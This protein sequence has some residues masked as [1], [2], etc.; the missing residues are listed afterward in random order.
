MTQA[1]AADA[2]TKLQ[3]LT[4]ASGQL[5]TADQVTPFNSSGIGGF[6]GVTIYPQS[7]NTG[8]ANAGANE[9]RVYQFV[10]PYA[11]TI[12]KVTVTVSTS[13]AGAAD[14]GIYNSAGTRLLY[15][16][17][18]INTGSQTTQTV[19][20][21]SGPVTLIAGVYYFAQTTNGVTPNFQ[22]LNSFT[23]LGAILNNNLVRLGTAANN[24]TAGVLPSTLGTITGAVNVPPVLAFFER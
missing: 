15:T 20:V 12:N 19:P 7:P 22:Q 8:P 2:Q 23:V 11:V 21:V 17:G 9:V 14:V 16:N 6:F 18:G 3:S 4:V 1:N 13:A 5:L 24:A 10:L